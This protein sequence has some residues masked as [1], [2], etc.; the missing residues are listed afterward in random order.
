MEVP[1]TLC[2]RVEFGQAP[3]TRFAGDRAGI[4]PLAWYMQTSEAPDTQDV[5]GEPAAG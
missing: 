3:G 4:P 5:T 2:P 1:V